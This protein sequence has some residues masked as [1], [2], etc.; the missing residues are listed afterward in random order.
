[1]G[2][3]GAWRLDRAESPSASPPYCDDFAPAR[4]WQGSRAPTAEPLWAPTG[5]GRRLAI[6]CEKS[7]TSTQKPLLAHHAY[8]GN[9]HDTEEGS[10]YCSGC[11]ARLVERDW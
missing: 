2:G 8:T 7:L 4:N 9:A 6:M 1:M 3:E 5:D 10:T 11:G